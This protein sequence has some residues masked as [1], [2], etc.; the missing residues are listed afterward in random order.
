MSRQSRIRAAALLLTA[1]L[2]APAALWAGEGQA[3][4][5]LAVVGAWGPESY[6]EGFD[7]INGTT[8]VLKSAAAG[9]T[10]LKAVADPD[11]PDQAVSLDYELVVYL[12]GAD[13]V[14]VLMDAGTDLTLAE[15]GTIRAETAVRGEGTLYLSGYSSDES[16]HFDIAGGLDMKKGAIVSGFG[17]VVSYAGV[18]E[19]GAYTLESGSLT[20]GKDADAGAETFLKIG[21]LSMGAGTQVTVAGDVRGGDGEIPD[22]RILVVQNIKTPESETISGNSG[23]AQVNVTGKGTLVIGTSLAENGDLSE[24]RKAVLE[25]VN[26]AAVVAGTLGKATLVTDA[27]L[28]LEEGIS[29]AVG[30]KVAEDKAG[31]DGV[32][33]GSDGR[34]IADFSQ[35]DKKADENVRLTLAE[36]LRAGAAAVTADQGAELILWNWNGQAFEIGDFAA[37]NVHAFG[38]A[39]IQIEDGVATRLWC[40]DFAG[41]NASSVVA[42]VETAENTDALAALPG[43]RFLIDSFAEEAVGRYSYAN[44]V[45]GALFLPVTSGL[46][47]A[48]ERASF[49]A[50]ETVMNHP[51][52]LYAGK[53]HWWVQGRSARTD[54]DSLFSGGSGSFGYRADVTQGTLGYDFAVGGKWIG[55]ASVTFA[56]IDT[57]S[58]G[59]IEQTTGDMSA[60]SFTAAAARRFDAAELRLAVTYTRASGDAEQRSITHRLDADTD[61]DFVTAAARVTATQFAGGKR[62]VLPYVQLSASTAKLDDSV[63]TDSTTDGTVAGE[64]FSTSA[65]RRYWATLQAGFDAGTRFTL[66]GKYSVAPWAGAAVRTAAGDRDWKITSALFDGSAAS[67]AEYD[68]AQSAAVR[69]RAGIEIA[70]SGQKEASA[71]LF[72]RSADKDAGPR[73]ELFAWSLTLSGEYEAA[74]GSEHTA[75]VSLTYRQLF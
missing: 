75:A 14:G 42:R 21:T 40:K 27:S 56:G 47:A 39:R 13:T 74:Q 2:S 34:W 43:Y 3:S 16:K 7:P 15:S 62:F 26:S 57:E 36:A 46:A 33:I 6:P 54:A 44:V 29:I 10:G 73:T 5:P 55:S 71:P 24:Q 60:A 51:F 49:D 61:I 20:V 17:S 68:S 11:F 50:L 37:E 59:R 45:D 22:G 52:E 63:I 32:H 35:S 58:R 9:V 8:L 41:L 66:A 12:E 30:E 4:G 70:R 23:P 53:G 25:T 1:A 38:G 69:V 28:T 67:E 72:L 48:G 19:V 65:D 31:T 18:G 64:A